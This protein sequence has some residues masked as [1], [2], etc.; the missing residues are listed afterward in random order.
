MRKLFTERHGGTKPRVREELDA[1]TVSGL[2]SLIAARIDEHWFGEDFPEMCGEGMGNAGTDLK[3][4]KLRMA[5]YDVPWPAKHGGQPEDGRVFDLVEFSYEHVSKPERGDYHG[6]LFHY[7]YSYDKTAGQLKFTMDVN[8]MF[9]RNGIAFEL[10]DGEVTRLA[11]AALQ[12]TLGRTI[13]ETGD[14]LLDELLE[15]ARHQFLS[16]DLK[17]RRRSLEKIWDA[18]ERLKT[19]ESG[20][21][22]KAQTEKLLRKASGQPELFDRL[23]AEAMELTQ[24]GNKF[25]IRHSETDR[26]PIEESV[27]VDYLFHRMFALIRLLLKAS[28][29]GG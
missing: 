16:R 17:E 12:E 26:I 21:D 8:R 6:Y 5:A 1:T 13:F 7:H 22:K 11:P 25:M 9:E 10:R 15:D 27:H 18:W 28:G 24:I 23:N 4:L 29:R 3:K 14:R 2:L 19:L 20:K